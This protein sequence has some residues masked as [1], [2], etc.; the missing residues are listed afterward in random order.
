MRRLIAA[1]IAVVP[2]W[3]GPIAAIAAPPQPSC[4]G[5]EV[6]IVG[7]RRAD[8]LTGTPGTDVILGLGGDD[9]I[10]ALGGNDR[11]CAGD[12]FDL[13]FAGGGHDVM[14]GGA[15]DD[16]LFGEG[17][18]DRLIGQGDV[19]TLFGGSGDDRLLAGSGESFLTEGLIGG[20]GDDLLDGGPGLDTAAFFDAPRG[21]SI[22][23]RDGAATGHGS[24]TLVG[25][26][27]ASG[28]NFDD[29][30]EGD[31][32]GNGLFGN[33]GDDRIFGLGSGDFRSEG[34]DVLAGDDGN[35]VLVGGGGADV[36]SYA[37]IPVPVTVDLRAGTASG[38]GADELRGIEGIWG[39]E[40]ADVLL[41]DEVRNAIVGGLGN[42]ELR[43]RGGRDVAVFSDISVSV[44]VDLDAGTATGAGTDALAGF[45][46]VWGTN[47]DDVL[48]GNGADNELLGLA[49][50]DDLSGRNG[51]DVLDGGEG[52]DHADGGA[53]DDVCLSSTKTTGCEGP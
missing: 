39:S 35:D 5:I 6:T 48:V 4:D 30:I 10:T 25:V 2:L 22:S 27:G 8:E 49:G 11:I 12:G 9:T 18:E 53:G 24:D 28:S 21:V 31:G 16:S 15:G 32:G 47:D 44:T 45:E 52:A 14:R 1:T 46:D 3:S 41:G 20:P 36:A 50:N 51:D 13:V 37:R 40:D 29:V 42:D 19:D 38:H 17:G 23:L 33:A 43:G 7:T 26:E 34:F